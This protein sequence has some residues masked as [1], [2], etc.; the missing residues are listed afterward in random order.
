MTQPSEATCSECG[1][2]VPLVGFGGPSADFI[3]LC[4]H[5]NEDY[6]GYH[7]LAL[8]RAV[9]AARGQPIAP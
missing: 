8:Q 3:A 1:F 9:D 5:Q 4:R 2:N 6:N 7:C